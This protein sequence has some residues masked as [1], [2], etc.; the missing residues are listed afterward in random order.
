MKFTSNIPHSYRLEAKQL[1]IQTFVSL[2][3]KY[4]RFCLHNVLE[5]CLQ[6]GYHQEATFSVQLLELK[7]HKNPM[8]CCNQISKRKSMDLHRP[9]VKELYYT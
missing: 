5:H 2:I 9:I 4:Q 7:I 6:Q 1:K 3:V 8:N